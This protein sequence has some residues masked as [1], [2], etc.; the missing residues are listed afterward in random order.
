MFYRKKSLLIFPK[1]QSKNGI[2]CYQNTFLKNQMI[3][4]ENGSSWQ[5]ISPEMRSSEEIRLSRKSRALK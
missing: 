5:K 3:G 4:P 2:Y 1:K